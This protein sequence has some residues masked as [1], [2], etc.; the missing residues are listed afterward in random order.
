MYISEFLGRRD[1]PMPSSVLWH[2][3]KEDERMTSEVP[4]GKGKDHKMD[5]TLE[6]KINRFCMLNHPTMEKWIK[7]YNFFFVVLSK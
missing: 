2:D 4:Q 1:I 7:A 6:E 3:Q 5:S